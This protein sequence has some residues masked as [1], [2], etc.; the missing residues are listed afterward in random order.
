[1]G[2]PELYTDKYPCGVGLVQTH[3]FVLGVANECV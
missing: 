1:M 3:S 2:E